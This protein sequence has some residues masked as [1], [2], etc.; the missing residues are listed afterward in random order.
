MVGSGVPSVKTPIHPSTTS[1]S[2]SWV[3][4]TPGTLTLPLRVSS[5]MT[6]MVELQPHPAT[7]SSLSTDRMKE[8]CPAVPEYSDV[9]VGPNSHCLEP[10]VRE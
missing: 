10:S 8:A 7:E 2:P 9:S 1:G 6:V 3:V 5:G 4:M